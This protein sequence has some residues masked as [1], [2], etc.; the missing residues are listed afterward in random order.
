[1]N[2]PFG[3]QSATKSILIHLDRVEI[4]SVSPGVLRFGHLDRLQLR[5]RVDERAQANALEREENFPFFHMPLIY[6]PG[7]D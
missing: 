3:P 2:Q 5:R 1:M 6:H 7:G 4:V